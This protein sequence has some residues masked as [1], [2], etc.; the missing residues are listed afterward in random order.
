MSAMDNGDRPIANSDIDRLAGDFLGSSYANFANWPL[1]Q[2]LF[3]FLRKRGLHRIANDGDVARVL[4]DR[5][6]ETV[7][8]SQ[9]LRYDRCLETAAPALGGGRANPLPRGRNQDWQG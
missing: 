1:E 3:G 9:H 2:R 5:V 6:T 7:R 4:T 8:W